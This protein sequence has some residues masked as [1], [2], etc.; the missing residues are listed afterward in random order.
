MPRAGRCSLPPPICA[1]RCMI[2]D[3]N[4]RLLK[5]RLVRF[6]SGVRVWDLGVLVTRG[7]SLSPT[8]VAHV[9]LTR[10]HARG[11]A[12]LKVSKQL[13]E[14]RTAHGKVEVAVDESKARVADMGRLVDAT[15]A[16][17]GQRLAALESTLR[18]HVQQTLRDKEADVFRNA[19]IM[20]QHANVGR[21]SKDGNLVAAAPEEMHTDLSFLDFHVQPP[22]SSQ[23]TTLKKLEFNQDIAPPP[24]P[25]SPDFVRKSPKKVALEPSAKQEAA[26]Q[27]KEGETAV[28]EG[29]LAAQ[30]AVDAK[31]EEGVVEEVG[32]KS[33]EDSMGGYGDDSMEGE[34]VEAAARETGEESFHESYDG[35]MEDAR[36]TDA[37]V[38]P[39][40]DDAGAHAHGA[41]G[42]AQDAAATKI[43]ARARGAR[44]R[45]RVQ[46]IKDS[47]T[48]GAGG[49][50]DEG[51]Q[52]GGTEEAG[53]ADE[54]GEAG[55]AGA[56]E[57]VTE[58]PETQ[59]E[60]A[61]TKEEVKS[62]HGKS[63]EEEEEEGEAP[64]QSEQ[65]RAQMEA[66]EDDVRAVINKARL[67]RSK[68]FKELIANDA[69]LLARAV[70]GS[71]N[72]LFHIAAAN[73]KKKIVKELL[74]QKD[75]I[76]VYARNNKGQ[77]A[78]DCALQYSFHELAE[79]LKEKH[80]KLADPPPS[81]D[82]VGA[83]VEGEA[84]GASAGAATVDGKEEAASI[85]AEAKAGEEAGG[86]A[87]KDAELGAETE[88]EGEGE[89][90][91]ARAAGRVSTG[92][93]PEGLEA[94][95]TEVS[96]SSA[97]NVDAEGEGEEAGKAAADD[98]AVAGG[99][100]GEGESAAPTSTVSPEPVQ[101]GS[102]TSVAEESGQDLPGTAGGNLE[103]A[104]DGQSGAE[105]GEG[106]TLA[107][108]GKSSEAVELSESVEELAD[109]GAG[110]GLGEKAEGVTPLIKNDDVKDAPVTP[111]EGATPLAKNDDVTDVPLT[112]AEGATPLARDDDV[113]D[114]P[115]TP[116]KAAADQSAGAGDGGEAGDIVED[117]VAES[118]DPAPV[119]MTT[120]Q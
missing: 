119:E 27:Q 83:E 92:D 84:A 70:D 62:N 117:V 1:R 35:G 48:A 2:S 88:A 100:T 98:A 113:T 72:T 68:D 52:Q 29:E 93:T 20:I 30:S 81:A 61:E 110:S 87:G 49:A 107:E 31:Q 54:V 18:D 77:N 97:A 44:D 59:A 114:V 120:G 96:T 63:E 12:D 66:L 47:N 74:R 46:A 53:G 38:L 112:P 103:R 78:L 67:G 80:P 13:N 79:Y 90:E 39:P 73:G 64:V 109:T 15:L 33:G 71:G 60:S 7:G 75:K 34:S 43:Q 23:E 24:R 55:E 4:C 51:D 56:P 28:G 57:R 94:E 10:T 37:D 32:Q 116:P 6:R 86:D 26:E 5:C 14:L 65:E 40:E 42:Q 118:P 85:G 106:A 108:G 99:A 41:D 25:S 17:Q 104:G 50:E 21:P 82:N 89:S 102:A 8:H 101:D 36:E 3:K 22:V 16:G 58:V 45:K 111:S 69:S 19:S 91:A 105:G 11:R 9:A 76:D 115:V 95:A